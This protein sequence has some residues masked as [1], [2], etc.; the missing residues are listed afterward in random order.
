MRRAREEDITEEVLNLFGIVLGLATKFFLFFCDCCYCSTCLRLIF[1]YSCLRWTLQTTPT[2][3][4]KLWS[5][6]HFLLQAIWCVNLERPQRLSRVLM[7]AFLFFRTLLSSLG[8]ESARSG[9][10]LDPPCQDSLR[11]VPFFVPSFRIHRL[12]ILLPADPINIC[13]VSW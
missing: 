6:L 5:T 11:L 3:S 2:I 9:T 7:C 10:G 13:V 4:E 1:R 8:C 12:V